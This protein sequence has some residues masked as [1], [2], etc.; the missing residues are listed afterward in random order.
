MA[1]F[2]VQLLGH[3]LVVAERIVADIG[4]EDTNDYRVVSNSQLRRE[5]DVYY[6]QI[7]VLAGRKMGWP[8]G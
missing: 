7:H 8:P 6:P 4:V 5:H 1:C 3:L 2:V